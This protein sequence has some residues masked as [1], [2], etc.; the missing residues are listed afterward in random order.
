[1]PARMRRA[2]PGWVAIAVVSLAFASA[3]GPAA[4]RSDSASSAAAARQAR[5]GASRDAWQ[6]LTRLQGARGGSDWAP[7]LAQFAAAPDAAAFGRLTAAWT[8]ETAA[9]DLARDYLDQQS[10]GE[11]DGQPR[12]VVGLSA[13]VEQAAARVAAAG[14]VTDPE[15]EMQARFATYRGLEVDAQIEQHDSLLGDLRA[16][17][18]LVNGRAC[19]T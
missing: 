5:D 7:Y 19:R 1:M 10:G 8:Q 4:I 3:C 9:A 18:D 2:C 15:A 11:Q 12:D 17:A 16:A 6:A 14:V 13:A